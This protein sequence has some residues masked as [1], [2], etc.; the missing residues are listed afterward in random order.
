MLFIVDD[1]AHYQLSDGLLG[2]MILLVLKRLRRS[3]KV[4]LILTFIT[5]IGKIN[6]SRENRGEIQP[7]LIIFLL[8]V[9]FSG[10]NCL[11]IASISLKMKAN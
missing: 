11:L 2:E 4:L 1:L 8:L 3:K 10:F 7:S 5:T 6:L 9:V